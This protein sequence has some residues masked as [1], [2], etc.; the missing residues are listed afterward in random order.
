[1]LHWSLDGKDLVQQQYI[2]VGAPEIFRN[3]YYGYERPT[4]FKA[5]P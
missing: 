5:Q 2:G 1:M 3:I 4:T